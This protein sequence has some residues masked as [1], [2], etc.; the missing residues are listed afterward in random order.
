VSYPGKKKRDSGI[1]TKSCVF[2]NNS[3]MKLTHVRELPVEKTNAGVTGNQNVFF[4]PS[5]H[6]WIFRSKSMLFETRIRNTP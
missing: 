2:C 1:V 3:V 5:I 6:P 4:I